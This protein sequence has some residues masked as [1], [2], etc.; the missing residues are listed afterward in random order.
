MPRF[1]IREGEDGCKDACKGSGVREGYEGTG[2]QGE[3]YCKYAR[4]KELE[5]KI[6]AKRRSIEE[7]VGPVGGVQSY[8][9][10]IPPTQPDN[11]LGEKGPWVRILPGGAPG[12]GKRR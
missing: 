6:D 4:L 2:P 1:A 10:P 9:A 5:E 11:A 7:L 8:D 3:K 12:S